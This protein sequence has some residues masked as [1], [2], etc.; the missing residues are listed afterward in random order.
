MKIAVL[1]YGRLNKCAEHYNNILNSIGM[2]HS[3]DFFLSSDNSDSELLHK[4]IHFYK[5]VA[6]TNEIIYYNFQ[7]ESYNGKAGETNINNM[8]RHFI[9]KKRVFD[10]LKEYCEKTKVKYDIIISLR[11]DLVINSKFIFDNIKDNTIYTPN[12]YDWRGLNDQIAYGNMY[13]MEK[14]MCIIDN[15]IN[16]LSEKKCIAHPE[17]LTLQNIIYHD[18]EMSKFELDYYIDK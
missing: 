18:I 17:S 9:N 12:C 1:I 7:L 11:V 4:F 10:L 6:Y 14:Y 5:P 8:T 2:E 3:I 15:C 13:V 16:L